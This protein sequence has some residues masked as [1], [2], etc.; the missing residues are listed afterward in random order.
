VRLTEDSSEV[1][2]LFQNFVCT[3]RLTEDTRSSLDAEYIIERDYRSTRLLV[4]EPSQ[5]PG[6]TRRDGAVSLTFE[7]LTKAASNIKT[8]EEECCEALVVL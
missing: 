1:F 2:P 3:G 6:S 7:T 4:E 5:K 8:P